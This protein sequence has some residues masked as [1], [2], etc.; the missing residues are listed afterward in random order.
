MFNAFDAYPE[1]RIVPEYGTSYSYTACITSNILTTVNGEKNTYSKP[2]PNVWG[3]G[4]PKTTLKKNPTGNKNTNPVNN[5]AS[6]NNSSL[7]KKSPILENN[8]K[9][10]KLCIE[11]SQK[12]HKEMLQSIN[13]KLEHKENDQKSSI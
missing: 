6:N 11:E 4:H 2:P 1:H 12:K 9:E 7:S 10:L 5:T 3:Q 13:T 8:Y